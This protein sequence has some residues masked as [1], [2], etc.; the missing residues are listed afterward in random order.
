MPICLSK[1]ITIGSDNGWHFLSR[2]WNIV[3][4]T[5]GNKLQWNLNRNSC[6]F[7]Q[8]NALKMSSEKWR[9]SLPP[10]FLCICIDASVG[11][12]GLGI[13]VCLMAKYTYVSM[14]TLIARSMMGPIWGRQ[15]PGGPHVGPM[16]MAIW[17]ILT[18][19]QKLGRVSDVRNQRYVPPIMTRVLHGR[20]VLI[21]RRRQC[22]R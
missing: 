2:C 14:Y 4:W 10:S 20:I 1:W 8:E 15:D 5:I 16:N 11:F 7:I 17:A 18:I 19:G 13:Y 6:I 22:L 3:N 12:T 9:L 21:S